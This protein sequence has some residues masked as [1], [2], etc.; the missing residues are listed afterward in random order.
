MTGTTTLG[1]QLAN[2]ATLRTYLNTNLYVLQFIYNG[3]GVVTNISFYA[4]SDGWT[5]HGSCCRLL[6]HLGFW[7]YRGTCQLRPV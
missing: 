7:Q 2:S 5:D 3:S 6:G 4:N 1:T